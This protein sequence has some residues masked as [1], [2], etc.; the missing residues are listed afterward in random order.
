MKEIKWDLQVHLPKKPNFRITAVRRKAINWK[1][2][3]IIKI[4]RL[5]KSLLEIL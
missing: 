5:S 4:L 1:K 2:A 3:T